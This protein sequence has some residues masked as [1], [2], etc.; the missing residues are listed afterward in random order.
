MYKISICAVLA[1]FLF[2]CASTEN[3][4]KKQEKNL[5]AKIDVYQAPWSDFKDPSFNY[6]LANYLTTNIDKNKSSTIDKYLRSQEKTYSQYIA[7]IEVGFD[8]SNLEKQAIKEANNI[9]NLASSKLYSIKT[10]IDFE[11]YDKELSGFPIFSFYNESGG[12]SF[13][14]DLNQKGVDTKGFYGAEVWL[15]K[16]G[17]VIPAEAKEAFNLIKGYSKTYLD[18]KAAVVIVYS[19]DSC[20]Q[21]KNKDRKLFCN[22]SVKNIYGY[23]EIKNIQPHNK[24][25]VELVRRMRHK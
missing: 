10:I 3:S 17:W 8:V 19:L 12:Y 4:E 7:A 22:G 23:N 15:S 1:L 11:K 21:Y 14:S 25:V 5:N 18:R 6:F 13:S 16:K 24:P 9:S 20:F 2:S